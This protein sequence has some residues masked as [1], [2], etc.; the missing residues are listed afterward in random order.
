MELVI[1]VGKDKENWGQLTALVNRMDCEKIIVVK[2]SQAEGFPINSKC[3]V[4]SI[5]DSLPLVEMKKQ[6]VEELKPKLSGDFEV[7]L[8]LASGSGKEHMALL[9]AL[10]SVPV[11]V[12]LAVYTKQGIVYVN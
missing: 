10:L 5:E 1:F 2:N 9:S 7:A 3:H 11:G 6:L 8:S 12:R 4:I